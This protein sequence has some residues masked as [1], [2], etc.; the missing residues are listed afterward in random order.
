MTAMTVLRATGSAGMHRSG[1]CAHRRRASVT[2]SG[3]R[4][5]GVQVRIWAII[6]ELRSAGRRC[7]G[8]HE[9]ERTRRPIMTWWD[10]SY[11]C[12]WRSTRRCASAIRGRAR[13][14][15]GRDHGPARGATR[16]GWCHDAAQGVRL[17]VGD[18]SWWPR[19]ATI[20]V[21]AGPDDL[22]AA[23]ERGE[24]CWAELAWAGDDTCQ[25]G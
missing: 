1:N 23:V 20:V 10:A 7:G 14:V 24:W 17:T 4:T 25:A 19:S 6:G 5:S 15:S 3:P 13:V 2:G 22:V 8:R 21:L 9:R 11:W 16:C 18:D 12:A